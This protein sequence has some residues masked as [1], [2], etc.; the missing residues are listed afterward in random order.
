MTYNKWWKK[1]FILFDLNFFFVYLLYVSKYIFRAFEARI[2]AFIGNILMLTET[3]ALAKFILRT[4]NGM[5][6]FF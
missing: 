2:K 1:G 4:W 6:E 3:Y 5:E